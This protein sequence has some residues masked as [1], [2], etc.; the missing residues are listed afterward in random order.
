M[1]EQDQTGTPR[2]SRL[3]EA[4][5]AV[6]F[7]PHLTE[8][9]NRAALAFRAAVDAAGWEGVEETATGPV[10]TLIRVAPEVLPHTEIEPRLSA[11]LASRN[12]SDAP[13]PSGRT[14]WRIPAA[15]GGVHGPQLAQAADLAGLS[16]SQAIESLT[17]ERLRVLTIGFAPGQPY[18][19]LL[20]PR[21]DIPRMTGLT[22]RVAPGAVVVAVRQIV[23]FTVSAPTG[24]RQVGLSAFAGFRPDAAEPFPLSAGDEVAFD[25]VSPTELARWQARAAEGHLAA[26]AE[27]LP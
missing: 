25:P 19:G 16:E 14:L 1:T 21:W 7:A 12:W 10:S 18:L 2:L 22:P 26:R 3:G 23:L 17:A 6:S 20:P 15:F 5:V 9:A 4:A 24:W 27:P 13:L 8:A 11:L